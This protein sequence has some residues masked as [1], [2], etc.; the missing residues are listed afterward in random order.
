MFPIVHRLCCWQK[1]WMRHKG[2]KKLPQTNNCFTLNDGIKQCKKECFMLYLIRFWTTCYIT[3]SSRQPHE[4][5]KDKVVKSKQTNR[6]QQ[7]DRLN[8]VKGNKLCS[9]LQMPTFSL[10]CPL[11]VKEQALVDGPVWLVLLRSQS[12]NLLSVDA[13][14]RV[15]ESKNLT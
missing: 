9:N 4:V 6:S 15:P 7:S 11:K 2:W 10:V 3:I 5:L 14:T 13:V 8:I 12:F 1:I